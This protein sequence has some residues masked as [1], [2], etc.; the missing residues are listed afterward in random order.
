ML[1]SDERVAVIARTSGRRGTQRIVNDFVQ[2]VRIEQGRVSEG[3]N[4]NWDQR[5][6]AE[7]MLVT[8]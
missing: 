7:F 1:A 3:W 6:L 4:Y 8:A 2:V 5:A